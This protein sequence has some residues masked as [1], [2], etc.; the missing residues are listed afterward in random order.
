MR[1]FKIPE[2]KLEQMAQSHQEV[3]AQEGQIKLFKRHGFKSATLQEVQ[4]RWD[5]EELSA[6]Q[7]EQ[8]KNE[9]TVEAS[10]CEN[11]PSSFL[12]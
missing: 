2:R 5:G 9:D 12:G 6:K 8:N 10:S 1:K 7:D 4:E 3:Q 11:A